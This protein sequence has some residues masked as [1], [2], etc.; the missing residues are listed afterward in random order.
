MKLFERALEGNIIAVVDDSLTRHRLQ[1]QL[2]WNFLK[3]TL[4]Q[5][6]I[7]IYPDKNLLFKHAPP[8]I[9]S[10][11]SFASEACH[12]AFD[13]EV[14]DAQSRLFTDK[15]SLKDPLLDVDWNFKSVWTVSS[16][17]LIPICWTPEIPCCI[18]C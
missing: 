10:L 16:S 9:D 7:C 4:N 15:S 6:I 5:Y 14:F 8:I 12:V 2:I 1:T 11:I 18:D 3:K 17:L 13:Q